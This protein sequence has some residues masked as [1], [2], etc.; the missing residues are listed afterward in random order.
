MFREDGL[1][2]DIE[3]LVAVRFASNVSYVRY[4]HSSTYNYLDQFSEMM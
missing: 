3:N 4:R 2:L 1:G